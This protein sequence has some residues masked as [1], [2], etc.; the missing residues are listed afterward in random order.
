MIINTEKF[1]LVARQLGGAFLQGAQN[2]NA[3]Q[4]GKPQTLNPKP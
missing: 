4:T 2:L 3:S 1:L